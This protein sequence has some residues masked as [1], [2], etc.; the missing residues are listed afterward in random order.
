MIPY[1]KQFIDEDNVFQIDDYLTV[2][3][4]LFYT[5]RN[6]RWSVNVKNITDKEYL[7][8]GG[9]GSSSITPGNPRAVY[10]SMSFSL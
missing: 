3:A 10:G 9:F 1:G 2:D 8:R 5:F 4:S 7:R 6:F